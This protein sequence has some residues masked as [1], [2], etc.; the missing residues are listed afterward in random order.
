VEAAFARLSSDVDLGM[1]AL[2]EEWWRTVPTTPVSLGPG[3]FQYQILDEQDRLP[4]NN[5][6]A[7]QMAQL[8]GFTLQAAEELVQRRSQG[9]FILHLGELPALNLTGFDPQSLL[10]LE[11]LVSVTSTGPVNIHTASTGVLTQLG[12]SPAFI[13]PLDQYR[14]GADRVVGTV[15]DGIF[16]DPQQ[17]RMTLESAMAPLQMSLQDQVTLDTLVGSTPPLLGVGSSTFRI[18]AEGQ[19]NRHGIRQKGE[20]VVERSGAPA[21]AGGSGTR[22]LGAPVTLNLREWYE[23]R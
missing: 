22:R 4:F 18:K 10:A 8:P 20:A 15:D 14:S 5:L 16:Q 1:D 17:I 23:P 2:R 7:G 11:P 6:L 9:K 19:T 12:F 3:T 13:D 21:A